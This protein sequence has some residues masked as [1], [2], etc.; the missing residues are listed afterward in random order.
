MK[1]IGAPGIEK[2]KRSPSLVKDK[3][4]EGQKSPTPTP[5]LQPSYVFGVDLR[6][7][8]VPHSAVVKPLDSETARVSSI[9][10]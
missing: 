2:D 6:P 8:R 4:V 5:L 7:S 1:L 3:R 10:W 9:I